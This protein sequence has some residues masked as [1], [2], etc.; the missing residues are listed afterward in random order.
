MPRILAYAGQ[1]YHKSDLPGAVV[2]IMN[3]MAGHNAGCSIS[4]HYF[5]L[6][7]HCKK[8]ARLSFAA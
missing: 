2:Y 5:S 3:S 7:A 6:N 4:H 8:L 1:N